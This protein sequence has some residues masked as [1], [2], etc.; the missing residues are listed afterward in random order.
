MTNKQKIR[1]AT[2]KSK[3]WNRIYKQEI[4]P[5]LPSP[6][7]IRDMSFMQHLAR[8]VG[9]P[10]LVNEFADKNK[11]KTSPST[12]RL[13]KLSYKAFHRIDTFMNI[14]GGNLGMWGGLGYGGLY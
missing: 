2:R 9:D 10:S 5:H 8:E 4:L 6:E 14:L 13:V 11:L 3:K 7:Q 12:R 1:K